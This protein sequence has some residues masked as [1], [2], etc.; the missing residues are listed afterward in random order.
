MAQEILAFIEIVKNTPIDILLQIL[1]LV[2]IYFLYRKIEGLN[3]RIDRVHI[4]ITDHEKECHKHNLEV[5]EKL[6]KITGI[7]EN[8][9]S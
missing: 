7:L 9:K 6:G 4:R 8:Q 2:L 1:I 3:A 5:T